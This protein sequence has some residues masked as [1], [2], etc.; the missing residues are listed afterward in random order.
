M[1]RVDRLMAM[2]VHLQSR[3]LVRAEDIAAHFEISVRTVYRDI[4]ALGEAGIPILGEAGVGY[5]LAKGY[6]LPP[7][8]F[9]AEEASALFMGGKLVEHLTD[10]SLRKHMESALLHSSRDGVAE[11]WECLS[12]AILWFNALLGIGICFA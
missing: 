4:A 12:Y 9:T 2:I 10:A 6:Y 11:F 8:M 1:N 5:G 7:V 3:R